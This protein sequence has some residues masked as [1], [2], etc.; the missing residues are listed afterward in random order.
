M[1]TYL[2]DVNTRMTTTK[3]ALAGATGN[4]GVP[5]LEVLLNANLSVTVLSRQGGTRP[6]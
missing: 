5:V 3:V 2:F 4:L 1:L 6:S